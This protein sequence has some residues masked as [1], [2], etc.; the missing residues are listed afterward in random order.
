MVWHQLVN[1]LRECDVR[2]PVACCLLSVTSV[3]CRLCDLSLTHLHLFTHPNDIPT[4]LQHEFAND[5]YN[6]L[7][8]PGVNDIVQFSAFPV[9]YPVNSTTD[10]T[11]CTG[12]GASFPA[13]FNFDCSSAKWEACLVQEHCFDGA[14]DSTTQL[15][16]A[17]FFKC[18]EGPFANQDGATNFALAAPCTTTAGLSLSKVQSCYDS[19]KDSNTVDNSVQKPFFEAAQ[20][21]INN[22]F[23]YVTVNGQPVADWV[24]MLRTVCDTY[25]AGGGKA[26]AACESV[27]FQLELKFSAASGL[28]PDNYN[29]KGD[30]ASALVQALDFGYSNVTFPVNFLDDDDPK[31]PSYFEA[32]T[33]LS[34]KVSR[35]SRWFE[36]EQG[37]AVGE[38]AWT[39][40]LSLVIDAYVLDAA[41][42]NTK[43]SI[44]D[45]NV[46]VPFLA[47]AMGDYGFSG[48]TAA[49]IT[50]TVLPGAALGL[51]GHRM[52]VGPGNPTPNQT[53]GG[54][55]GVL[56]A[57]VA[58]AGAALGAAITV[59]TTRR[60]ARAAAAPTPSSAVTD[61]KATDLERVDV[62][63][64]GAPY[65]RSVS[66][67]EPRPL[68][69]QS[70]A[71]AVSL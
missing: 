7:R 16:L 3:T 24:T 52:A 58:V 26:P 68:A 66:G 19:I 43:A 13:G 18:Y 65:R 55:S 29:T 46:F 11:V 30:L 22:G 53:D 54:T 32:N 38:A 5:I 39:S 36:H 27:R 64:V 56:L 62:D 70:G 40:G 21:I 51:S 1:V 28:T 63:A 50:A 60:Q 41:L 69:P 34:A 14:C 15:Q 49:D 61:V 35:A 23:P 33:T 12:T 67:S 45:A 47:Q 8:S 25:E 17:H 44:G 37:G 2:L 57:G 42:V 31:T 48:I 59:L 71:Q 20:P 4:P 10:T 6:A 9:P